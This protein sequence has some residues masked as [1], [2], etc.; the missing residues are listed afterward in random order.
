MRY[1]PRL[2]INFLMLGKQNRRKLYPSMSFCKQQVIFCLAGKYFDV[3]K[4]LNLRLTF[5]PTCVCLDLPLVILG[6]WRC[7]QSW[8]QTFEGRCCPDTDYWPSKGSGHQQ[9][10]HPEPKL[11]LLTVLRFVPPVLPVEQDNQWHHNKSKQSRNN[12]WNTWVFLWQFS[13]SLFIGI[14]II[15]LA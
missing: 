4:I 11:R 1:C 5:H 8:H 7:G 3:Q 15:A 6:E 9:A 12:N 14:I 13:Q 10:S 2:T